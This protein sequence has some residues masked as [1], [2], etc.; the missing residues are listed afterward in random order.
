MSTSTFVV[1]IMPADENYRK[2]S[3]VYN[4]CT[5]AGIPVPDE[6]HDFFRGEKPDASGMVIDLDSWNKKGADIAREW[7]DDH[8]R[9]YEIDVARIPMG[10]KTIRFYGNW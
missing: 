3:A 9:G 10:V 4:A 2:M 6:V 5:D 8:Y 7:S 1:G